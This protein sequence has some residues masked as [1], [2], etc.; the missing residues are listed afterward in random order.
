MSGNRDALLAA[1]LVTFLRSGEGTGYDLR[2]IGESIGILPQLLASS[3]ACQDALEHLL[4]LYR[5][6]RQNKSAEGRFKSY[7][8][9]LSS[10]NSSYQDPTLRYAMGTLAATQ[11]LNWSGVSYILSF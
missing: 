6:M 8:K 1:E 7:G 4:S 11:L 9:A 5:S 10:L 3:I 2:F